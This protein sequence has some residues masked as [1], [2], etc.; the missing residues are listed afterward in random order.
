MNENVT[1]IIINKIE[2][3]DEEN[4]TEFAKIVRE[5]LEKAIKFDSGYFRGIVHGI[6]LILVSLEVVT[7]NDAVEIMDVVNPTMSRY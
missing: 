3:Y 7:S 4:K 5:K 6:L 2:K 1:N